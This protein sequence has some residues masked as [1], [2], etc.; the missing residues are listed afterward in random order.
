MPLKRTRSHLYE[1]KTTRV[2]IVFLLAG[3]GFLGFFTS[4][5]LHSPP[6]D[7][8]V[9]PP[10]FGDNG[11]VFHYPLAFASHLKGDPHAGKKI[12]NE[13]CSACHANPPVVGVSAP[14]LGDRR[15]WQQLSTQGMDTLY[16]VVASGAGAMPA[17]GGCF[18]CS[19]AELRLAMVY[20]LEQSHVHVPGAVRRPA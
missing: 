7:V 19:D 10:E 8:P 15:R 14:L 2:W 20:L 4:L 5:R 3:A 6:K 13:F 17:R 1:K 18:E 11:R 16:S 12:Y 9:A